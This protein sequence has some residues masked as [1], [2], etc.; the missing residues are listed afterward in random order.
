MCLKLMI[1]GVPNPYCYSGTTVLENLADIR[2]QALD[3]FEAAM[4]A[5]RAE[6]PLPRGRRGVAQ[7][8]AKGDDAPLE[9]QILLLIS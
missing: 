4:T 1:D 7:Y 9:R 2:S 3:D 8:K 6:E 5:L